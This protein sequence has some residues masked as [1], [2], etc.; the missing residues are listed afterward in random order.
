M[1]VLALVGGA[2]FA[3][4]SSDVTA[5]TPPGITVPPDA[6]GPAS[7]SY[8]EGRFPLPDCPGFDY[9]RCDIRQ[10][11]CLE[12]L[13]AIARCLHGSDA[14]LTTPDVTFWTEDE[15]RGDLLGGLE[16]APSPNHFEIALARFGLT[17]PGALEPEAVAT[18]LAREWIAY[19][20]HSR[21]E[22]I[23]IEHE[24]RTD[25]LA[26]DSIVVH[27]MI[28][29][30]QDRE[31]DLDAFERLYRRDVDGNLRGASL[32]EGEARFHERRYFAALIGLD[33]DDIDL[34][35]SFRN[36]TRNAER[37]LFA[38][39]DLYSASQLSVPYAHGAEY[40]HG[41]WA[42]GGQAA[43]RASFSAPPSSMHEILATIWHTEASAL[44]PFAAP[45]RPE[46]S[47]IELAAWTSMGAWSLY[48]LARR[49][50]AD[51][52]LGRRIALAWSGD[53]LEVFTFGR[54]ETAARWRL[55]FTSTEAAS[56]FALL[57]TG[58]RFFDSVVEG[59]SVTLWTSTAPLPEDLAGLG[60]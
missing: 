33:I 18:R 7:E 51:E 28:H 50:L 24:T 54:A 42:Q 30:F 3:C 40:V 52:M 16:P 27:E 31:Y 58:Q 29:A 8:A 14:A 5:I 38:Q 23:V 45:S 10:R 15:A 37:W 13:G 46:S 49:A 36:L 53:Q 6:G 1:R 32:V 55:R 39:S 19:Y 44:T 48:L 12:N 26:E 22:I 17:E 57:L 47:G 4:S 21:K 11:P 9:A 34:E 20:H 35:F 41:V 43:V 2:L 60:F 25:P 59:G 56:E